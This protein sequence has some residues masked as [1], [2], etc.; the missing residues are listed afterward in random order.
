MVVRKVD[1]YMLSIPTQDGAGVK[2]RR[3]FWNKRTMDMDPFLLLDMF[4]SKDPED[5]IKGFPLHP[6]RGIQT[7]TYFINGHVKHL[8]S[9]GNKG[10]IKS[11]EFQWMNAGSGIIHEEMPQITQRM[12]G[13]QLWINLPSKNKMSTPE[14]YSGTSDNI[15]VINKE[16]HTVKII[17]GKHEGKTGSN[18]PGYLPIQIFDIDI[19]ENQEIIFPVNED[20]NVFVAVLLG[21]LKICNKTMEEKS[22]ATFQNGN[23]IAFKTSSEPARVIMFSGPKLN[24]PVAWRGPIVMNTTKE[25]EQAQAD[26]INDT[27]TSHDINV[28]RL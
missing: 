14:Y 12:L 6:H 16:S 21:G 1:Q 17:S 27:F 8:D 18:I 23:S 20:Y 11:G 15:P 9:L 3:I 2:L 4:D 7:L 25:L 13:F 22:A 26:L 19:K 28:D 10:S 5:Y 24:E